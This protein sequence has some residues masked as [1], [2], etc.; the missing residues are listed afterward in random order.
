MSHTFVLLT[1][2]QENEHTSYLNIGINGVHRNMTDFE[3]WLLDLDCVQ[4]NMV[5]KYIVEGADTTEITDIFN[6]IPKIINKKT[7][8]SVCNRSVG[9]WTQIKDVTS[10]TRARHCVVYERFIFEF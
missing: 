4:A 5:L 7:F 3:K 9:P 6:S 8:K 10:C 1:F 2:C